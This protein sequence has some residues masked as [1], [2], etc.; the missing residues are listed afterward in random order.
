MI[1]LGL[2][3]MLPFVWM[4]STSLKPPEEVLSIRP[5]WIPGRFV[6]DNFPEVWRQIPFERFYANSLLV[7]IIMTLTTT[8][9]AA[10][11]GYALAKFTFPGRDIIFIG[12]LAT[13][14]VPS[15]VTF[16]PLY[17]A[18][19]EFGWVN[20]YQGLVVPGLM[21]GF[22]VFLMRQY[23]QTLPT[24]LIEAARMDGCSEVRVF[25]DIM[26]P[27][28][29]PALATVAIFTFMGH[30]DEFLWPLIITNSVNMKT[31]PLGMASFQQQEAGYPAHYNLIMAAN[32]TALVPVMI[33]FLS[34]QRYFVKGITAGSVK[35]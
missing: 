13:M 23:M 17:I 31:I 27:L 22:S 34:L 21:S 29:T 12:I 7:G 10:L 9:F 18:F 14:M 24:E 16:I 4:V 28:A 2:V 25:F 8:A 33:V 11:T 35:G 3:M 30:W 20:T 26:L 1:A 6:W 32:L 19:A 15:Q 5:Q